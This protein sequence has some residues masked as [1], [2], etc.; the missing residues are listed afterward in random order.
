MFERDDDVPVI[1]LIYAVITEV[2][3]KNKC[4]GYSRRAVRLEVLSVCINQTEVLLDIPIKPSRAVPNNHTDAGIGTA[5]ID[6]FRYS[7]VFFA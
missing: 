6:A 5:E 4:L 1:R 2:I 7:A 3:K